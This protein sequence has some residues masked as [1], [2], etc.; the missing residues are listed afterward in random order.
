MQRN[1]K[2]LIICIL[3]LLTQ[4]AIAQVTANF[5][6][7]VTSGCSPLIVN[8]SSTSTGSPTSFTWDFGDGIGNSNLQNPSYSYANPG[9]YTVTLTVS[10]GSSTDSETKTNYIT[11]FRNPSA[12]FSISQDTVCE[13]IPITFT[14]TSTPGDGAIN[15][16]SWTFNDGTPSVTGVSSTS[17]AFSN[18]GS[19]IRFYVPVLLI[20]D[21]NGCNS[22]YNQDTVWIVPVPVPG[23]FIASVNSC[24]APATA[25]FTNTSTNTTSFQWDFGDPASGAN[26]TS[27]LTNPSHT[28]NTAG[29]YTV[30][31]TAGVNGCDSSYTMQVSILQPVADFSASDTSICLGETVQFTNTGSSGSLNWNFGDPASGSNNTSTLANPTHTF[32][33]VGTFVT[34]LI[35]SVGNCRDTITR[36]IQVNPPPVAAFTSPDRQGCSVPFPVTFNATTPG[37]SGWSWTF[38]DPGSGSNTATTQNPS[39]TYNAFGQY[40]VTL[41]VTDANGCKDT[42]TQVNYVQVIAPTVN[43]S[44]TDSGCVGETFNFN[45]VVTSPADPTIASYQ[46]NW[47]DGNTSTVTTAGTSHTYNAAGIYDVTLTITTSTGCT[48]TL[49]RTQFIRVGTRPTAGITSPIDTICFKETVSFLDASLPPVTGWLWNFGDGG[50]STTQNPSHQFNMDTSGVS[51]P[52][53]ITLIAFY[54]GCPDTFVLQ[55]QIVVLGPIPAFT[56]TYNCANP[57]SVAFTNTSGGAT[58]YS[59]DFADGSGLSTQTSPTHVFPD[60]TNYPVTL[61][62]TNADNG[63]VVETTLVAQIREP[64]ANAVVNTQQACYPGTIYFTGS[65]SQDANQY[66]WTFGEGIAGVRDTTRFADTLHLY[67]SVGN[68]TA[69]LSITDIHGCIDTAQVPIAIVGPDAHFTASPLTDC[70][71]MTVTFRDSSQTFGGAIAQWSW[72]FGNGNT[73]VTTN[74]T[75]TSSYTTPGNYNVTLTVTD[76]NG[77]TDVITLTNYIRPTRPTPIL[78]FNPIDTNACINETIGMSVNPGPYVANPLTYSWNF[79]DGNTL[80]SGSSNELHSYTAN[81]DYPVTV[82]V[83]DANGCTD[84]TIRTI[85]VY[86]TPASVSIT[87]TDTCVV[88]NGIKK[89]QV[90][91]T[92]V[93]DSNAY[94]SSWSWNLGVTAFPNSSLSTVQ[95]AYS[96]PPGSYDVSLTVLN[97]FGCR[98][99]VILPGAIVVPGPTGSFTFAPDSGCSPLSV[100]FNGTSTGAAFY[101][102]DFGD[103]TVLSE[104]ELDT[105][106][107]TYTGNGSYVPQFYLGFQLPVSQSFCYVPVPIFDTV[108]VT[109]LIG[110]DILE[111]TIVVTDGEQDTLHVFVT[112]PNNNPPYTY[113]WTPASQ[114]TQDL[115]DDETFY[116]TTTGNTQYYYVS[117]PFGVSGCSAIDS[118][119]VVYRVCEGELKIPNVFTPDDD[120]KN[121]TYYVKDLCNYDGFEF[122]IYNRW[123]RIIYESSDPDFQWD[124]KT[125]GGELANEGVYYYVMK[126]KTKEL[127]GWIQLIRE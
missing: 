52:F 41:I 86:T 9:V 28:Y 10:N 62:A 116:A 35:V 108:K 85:K 27:S 59:W 43:F 65:G 88:E 93:S 92:I 122:R 76:V 100:T 51:D 73:H 58:S 68:Y 64:I 80:P 22:T 14:S 37:I 120:G 49:T 63:C 53:D 7:N 71:P 124:G 90:Y 104:V 57:Y 46:W 33:T 5:T 48:A 117:V 30:T 26:N 29:T 50:S 56:I 79:G 118:V 84:S 55:D 23:F 111:D 127:K 66:Q 83:T 18:G 36:N 102:W 95:Y 60:N 81:G 107:H 125:T 123:G 121:D 17:H 119:L 82:V 114:V 40:S 47:G 15:Q 109:S 72:N 44:Q 89:A 69:T 77:C 105:V 2:L 6:S 115:L 74:S 54:N 39:H 45:A 1:F 12:S 70:A 67:N 20:N 106:S 96:V 99:T 11:V 8:F 97:Q 75:D 19:S 13:N 101:S 42:L 126:T 34:Q 87:T 31:L 94:V 4:S 3:S 78:A 113:N 32:N 25:Q 61:E 103:G 112:D 24:S 21:V 110:V 16:Y 38:G 98:D 91:A